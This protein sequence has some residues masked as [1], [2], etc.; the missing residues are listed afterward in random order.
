MRAHQYR[1]PVALLAAA[2]AAGGATV[3]LRPRSGVIEPAT[4]SAT[5]YFTDAEL[6]K[7]RDY[8]APQRALALG[9]LALSGAV[10][11]VLTVRPPRAIRR[12]LVRAG[13]RP[14]AGAAAAGSGYTAAMAVVE[15]PLA[16]IA[17]RRARNVGLATQTWAPWLADVAKATALGALLTG[18][19][20]GIAESVIRRFPGRWWLPGAATVVG[21]STLM[22]FA[23]P[24]VIDPIFNKFER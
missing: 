14:I 16:A 1:L 4:A 6:Q 12:V 9:S 10:L 19:G 18:A 7:G 21:L 23:A 24:V 17:H 5:D 8:R 22:V 13:A 20:T 2:A 3:L 15:L 11:V